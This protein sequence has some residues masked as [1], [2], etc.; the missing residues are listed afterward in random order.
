VFVEDDLGGGILVEYDPSHDVLLGEEPDVQDGV[1][2]LVND[3]VTNAV[4]GDDHTDQGDDP[5]VGG[6]DISM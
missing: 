1:P 6:M 5:A 3:L 2:D 4:R